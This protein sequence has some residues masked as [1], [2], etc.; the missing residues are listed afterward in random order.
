[1]DFSTFY[2]RPPAM[3]SKS[4]SVLPIVRTSIQIQPRSDFVCAQ[5][6]RQASSAIPKASHLAKQPPTLRRYA[7]SSITDK[8]RK[9]IWGT[10]S[11]PGQD[12]PYGSP[13]VLD[14][15]R[16]QQEKQEAAKTT[17]TEAPDD[18]GYYAP[19]TTWDGLKTVGRPGWGLERWDEDN[20][21][22]G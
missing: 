16:E 4:R 1:M 15:R 8:L 2:H 12:D 18:D 21:F 14:K 6:R 11:P 13:S 20:V 17:K 19:A 5:C 9:K 3:A 7:S 22:E 10:D